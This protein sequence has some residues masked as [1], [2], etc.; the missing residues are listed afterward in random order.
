MIINNPFRP[1]QIVCPV[2]FSE[3]SDLALK[4]AATGARVFDAEL[5]VLY[6]RFF[7]VPR[8]FVP[9]NAEQITSSLKSAEADILNSLQQ[10]VGDILGGMHDDLRLDFRVMNQ[11]PIEAIRTVIKEDACDLI[12]MGTHGLSGVKRFFMGSITENIVSES[13]VPVFTI[14]QKAHDFIEAHDAGS[15]PALERILCPCDLKTTSRPAFDV[16]VSIA[17]LFNS[18]LTVLYVAKAGEDMDEDD[19]R[20]RI[21]SI[22]GDLDNQPCPVEITVRRGNSAEEIVRQADA[23]KEDIIVLGAVHK[24]FLEDTFLGRTTE[25]VMR[26]APVPVLVTPI[27]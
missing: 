7:E 3:L 14:R 23:S 21:C 20:E 18:R 16:A 26:H 11:H 8:Y 2:D 15:M 4:Y 22:I 1:K 6:A 17:D 5:A 12:V 25:L 13:P 9:D 27:Y 19:I 24:S 10:H